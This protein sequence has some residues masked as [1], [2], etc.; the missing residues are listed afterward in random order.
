MDMILAG[1]VGLLIVAILVALAARRLHL[2]YTV[3]L[4]ATGMVLAFLPLPPGPVLTH[5][6][7]Y[8]VVLPPLLFEAAISIR[9]HE[10]RRD[11]LPVLVLSTLGVAISALAVA[12]GMMGLL[13]WPAAAALVF[14][15]LIAATD[16]V[17]V[18]AM[19]KNLGLKGRL[20]LL[21]E[22]ESLFNDGVAAV[23]FALAL[24]WAT[25][26]DTAP[27]IGPAI[28]SLVTTAGGGVI[29][30]A[31]VGIAAIA[32]AGRTVDHLIGAAVTTAAAYGAFL[33]AEHW[34]FS[35]VLATVS[36]GL[37][38]GNPEL[39]GGRA[40]QA[41]SMQ[42]REFIHGVWEFAAFIANSFVFLLIGVTVAGI[43]FADFGF[44]PILTAIALVLAAR[45]LTVYPL[46][47]PFRSTRWAIPLREQHVLWWGGLRGALALALALSLPA[48][49]AYGD[50]IKIMTFGV[51]VFSVVFQGVT[52]PLLLRKLGHVSS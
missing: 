25:A 43:P 9:W 20:R 40:R 16:P 44:G 31:G 2:P 46:S 42:E 23:L 1:S 8:V 37:L 50:A 35:G 41:F 3:G 28:L 26:P 47:L 15:V 19:F 11:M 4:V 52:M 32:I 29:V 6:F 12:G 49:M 22:S 51:V 33:L 27:G 14:G 13:G 17:A 7:I 24:A 45:A 10:L 5:D 39:L 38:V 34:H 18:I 21:V 48:T 30:G 36:A